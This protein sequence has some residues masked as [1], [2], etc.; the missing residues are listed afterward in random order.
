MNFDFFNKYS[1]FSIKLIWF[2]CIEMFGIAFAQQ[3][4]N[5]I[6]LSSH[7]KQITVSGI[8]QRNLFDYKNVGLFE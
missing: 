6:G 7:M 3:V 4:D 8:Y 1:H 5:K 2:K